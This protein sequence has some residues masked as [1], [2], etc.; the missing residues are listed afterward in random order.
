MTVTSASAPLEVRGGWNLGRK[1]LGGEIAQRPQKDIFWMN[2]MSSWEGEQDRKPIWVPVGQ[3]TDEATPC[4]GLS[5]AQMQSL[6]KCQLTFLQVLFSH[7]KASGYI[8]HH[9]PSLQWPIT[10]LYRVIHCQGEN[11][12]KLPSHKKYAPWLQ[13]VN[14][15]VPGDTFFFPPILSL[16]FFK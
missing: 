14:N 8:H 9:L 13:I 7:L 16:F 6:W 2:V 10:V 12:R 5:E 11:P 1:K 15:S 3:G 4:A